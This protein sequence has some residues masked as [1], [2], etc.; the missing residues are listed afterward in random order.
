MWFCWNQFANGGGFQ[1]LRD[2]RALGPENGGSVPVIAMTAFAQISDPE[3]TSG[4]R[5][6]FI[7]QP[8]SPASVSDWEVKFHLFVGRL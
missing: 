3:S 7:F 1:L 5:S 4:H 6:R 2:I 8:R